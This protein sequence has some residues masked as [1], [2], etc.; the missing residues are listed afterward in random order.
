MDVE[1]GQLLIRFGAGVTIDQSADRLLDR[2]D[3][4]VRAQ[5]HGLEEAGIN[6]RV[7]RLVVAPRDGGRATVALDDGATVAADIA[8]LAA[9]RSLRTCGIGLSRVGANPGGQGCR[10]TSA[11]A[12]PRARGW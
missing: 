2:E 9:G 4:T 1:L 8:V 7:R 5:P 10:A 6:A 12:S 11:A 3:P